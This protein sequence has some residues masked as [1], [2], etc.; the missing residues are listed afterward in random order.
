MKRTV[1]KGIIAGLCGMLAACAIITVNVYFPEKA[2]KEAYKSL[3]EMLLKRDEEKQAPSGQKP[4][5]EKKAPET[6]PQSRLLDEFPSFSLVSE[7][8]ASDNYAD[9]LAVELSSMPD[10]LKAY[11][12]MHQ[13]LP[14]INALLDAGA[15]GITNQGLITVRDKTK[16]SSQ[17]EA[18]VKA[19]NDSRK[20]VITGMAKAI[21]KLNKQKE[22]K[23]ALD[24][25]KGKAAT[26][27][28]DAKRDEAK[29]GWWVQ[30]ANGRWVQK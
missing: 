5:E 28:A 26:T 24:Q 23:A 11:D 6:S 27:Y 30:L 19:E 18:L 13:R 7:A 20:T 3:D 10:V 1:L 12:E 15:V 22:S 2:V 21:L 25:V 9:D 8:R 16:V 4:A 17:D 29:P 14:R